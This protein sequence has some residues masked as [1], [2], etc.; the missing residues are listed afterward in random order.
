MSKNFK[1]IT[2]AVI[3]ALM[4]GV[5][6]IALKY[7]DSTVDS[8]TVVWFRFLVSFL[9]LLTYYAIRRPSALRILIHPPLLVIIGAICLSANFLLYMMG[10]HYI[11][12]GDCQ[13]ISQLGPILLGIA[14]VFIFKEKMNKRQISGFVIAL[15][16]FG[17]FYGQQLKAVTGN[18]K[19]FNLGIFIVVFA[20]IAWASYGII[21]KTLVRK[22][23]PQ[24]I[25]LFLYFF[26][27]VIFFP[28][29]TP[30]LMGGL[31]TLGWVFLIFAAFNTL[32]AYGALSAAFK[33]IEAS[34]ISIIVTMN[35]IITFMVMGL[36]TSL[37]IHLVAP[38]HINALGISGG[39]LVL[40]G[41]ILVILP[42]KNG[43]LK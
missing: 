5:L 32:I 27:A 4:W 26:P 38:E 23:A 42:Q 30:R 10:I 6:A 16:G 3:T 40:T 12:P 9:I 31:N 41:A 15:I 35:P 19:T 25:N 2:L 24:V 14:S 1:G 22:Y 7:I 17:V 39:I 37:G 43:S 11:T 8:V 20:S 36:L 21:Q 28:F 13:L 29:S 33:Y 34:K 18:P